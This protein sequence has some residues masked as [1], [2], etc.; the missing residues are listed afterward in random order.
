MSGIQGERIDPHRQHG[1]R[2]NGQ[3][4]FPAIITLLLVNYFVSH[5]RVHSLEAMRLV[6]HNA[7][8]H[9]THH[10]GQ[11]DKQ[12]DAADVLLVARIVLQNNLVQ[13]R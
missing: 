9:R 11:N 13:Q 3:R 7:A 5:H 6:Q 8:A 1:E 12:S 4:S 10:A 2:V